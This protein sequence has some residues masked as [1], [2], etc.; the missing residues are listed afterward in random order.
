M[1]TALLEHQHEV[2]NEDASVSLVFGTTGTT[3]LTTTQPVISGSTGT[4]G[5]V[6]RVREDGMSLGEDYSSGKTAA[7]DLAVLT[8]DA[9]NP[10]QAGSDALSDLER[11]WR[12]PGFR[13]GSGKYAIL[14][15][16]VGGRTRRAYG[17]PR[18][19]DEVAGNLTIKGVTP[20]LCDF[21]VPDG[22]WYDDDE[23]TVTI[24]IIASIIS[25]LVAPLVTPLTTTTA[26]ITSQG[27][28]IGGKLPTWPVI[29]FHGPVTNPK[30]RFNGGLTVAI[31]TVIASGQS[32]TVDTRPWQRTVLRDDGASLAGA[33][34]W[35]TPPMRHMALDPGVYD[36][37]FTGQDLSGTAWCSVAWRGAYSRW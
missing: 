22:T 12:T 3:Y 2:T 15:S 5:D 7:F 19:Y 11:L 13:N 35:D 25:G 27:G 17:R 30:V 33:F 26:V 8:D 23:S 18:R 34:T 37:T 14:R 10:T 21:F 9:D 16:M 6:G 29:T 1:P 24:P 36:I 32:V 20:V 28:T 4:T 31:N